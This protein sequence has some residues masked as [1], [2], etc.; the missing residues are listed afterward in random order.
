MCIFS[1]FDR[2]A[3]QSSKRLQQY[4]GPWPKLK[5]LQKTDQLKRKVKQSEKLC[6][7]PKFTEKLRI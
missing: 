7:E 2:K 1:G 3:I 4:P 5:Q 6:T